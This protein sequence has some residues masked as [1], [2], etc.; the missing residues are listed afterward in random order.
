MT[1]KRFRSL[2]HLP[3]RTMNKTEQEHA[4]VLKA[5][6]NAHQIERWEFE[7]VKLFIGVT[8]EGRTMWYC[9]D[10]LVE[11]VNH[12]IEFHEVKGG[13]IMD[14]AYVKLTAAAR[15]YPMFRFVLYQK[16]RSGW[17]CK[18]VPPSSDH[19]FERP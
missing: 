9:P 10:F 11:L 15:M 3:A 18:E 13:F 19:G 4:W 6:V 12:Q 5:A 16:R 2:G 14:D 7:A 8:P 1:G 17:E